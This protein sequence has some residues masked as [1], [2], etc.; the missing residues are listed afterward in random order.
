MITIFMIASLYFCSSAPGEGGTLTAQ[1]RRCDPRA[2]AAA[3]KTLPFGTI[4]NVCL[5][6]RCV[7]VVVNDR[8]PFIKGRQLDLTVGAAR[9]LGMVRSG[10][11]RV[12]VGVP[13]PR[14]RPETLEMMA[15]GEWQP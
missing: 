5:G 8:G 13:I 11:A 1:G 10:V 15:K 4:L 12:R 9:S 14:P 3:H 7:G 6:R 2:M